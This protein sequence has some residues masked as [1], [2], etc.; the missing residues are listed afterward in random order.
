MAF[1]NLF[2]LECFV[3]IGVFDFP[4]KLLISLGWHFYVEFSLCKTSLVINPVTRVLLIKIL[5][6]CRTIKC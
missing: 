5:Y 6:K 1:C 4:A 2:I 3:F